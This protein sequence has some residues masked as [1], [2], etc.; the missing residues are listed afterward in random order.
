MY[1]EITPDDV[2]DEA[3]NRHLKLVARLRIPLFQSGVEGLFVQRA[4]FV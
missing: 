4:D 1:Q 3:V 2:D